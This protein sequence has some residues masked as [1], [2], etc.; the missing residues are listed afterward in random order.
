V[1]HA[2]A[3]WF[4]RFL[5]KPWP[6]L[7]LLAFVVEATAI[8]VG[9]HYLSVGVVVAVF[10][11]LCALP[12]IVLDNFRL[13]VA[14]LFLMIVLQLPRLQFPFMPIAFRDSIGV[15]F[16]CL[17]TF[18]WVRERIDR[19]DFDLPRNAKMSIW[20]ALGLLV[21]F[22]TLRGLAKDSRPGDV[23]AELLAIAY[24]GVYVFALDCIRSRAHVR[25]VL[26]TIVLGSMVVCVEYLIMAT[27]SGGSGSVGRV[28]S[29][30][31]NMTLASGSILCAIFVTGFVRGWWPALGFIPLV[32]TI[33]LSGQ[34]SLILALPAGLG[35]VTLL[36]LRSRLARPLRV[37][38]LAAAALLAVGVAWFSVSSLRMGQDSATVG[39]SLSKRASPGESTSSAS[40]VIRAISFVHVWNHRIVQ[41]PLVGWGIGNSAQIPILRGNSFRTIRVDNSYV[42]LLWKGGVITLA[43]FLALYGAFIVAGWR[44]TRHRDPEARVVAMAI[45][46]TLA[47]V[48][49]A[50]LASSMITH[51]RFSA[52]W[53]TL[54]AIL[55]RAETIY[56]SG[57][58]SLS[59]GRPGL[60]TAETT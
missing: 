31:A 10:L 37:G 36:S 14:L 29:Q 5:A 38:A 45:V 34:R 24:Y 33:L 22:L 13:L 11:L 3:T 19:G 25:A 15:G 32:I 47:G 23:R 54:M 59:E 53:A 56:G 20:V 42:T 46:G 16:L 48:L 6:L 40:L 7:V 60:E 8:L 50:S 1:S 51:Y 43:L 55:V 57:S 44:L 41:E 27:V 30:Q 39:E 49:V 18:N 21:V 17:L 58:T 2:I 9:L 28:I 12:V 4:D 35:I 52:I 26:A